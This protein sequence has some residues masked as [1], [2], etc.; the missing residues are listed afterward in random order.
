M[1]KIHPFGVA[2]EVGRGA[3]GLAADDLQDTVWFREAEGRAIEKG[4]FSRKQNVE[5]VRQRVSQV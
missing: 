5:T 3:A 2:K 4:H 1:Q